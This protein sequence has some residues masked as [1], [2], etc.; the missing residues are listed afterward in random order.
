MAPGP[1]VASKPPRVHGIQITRRLHCL[2][3]CAIKGSAVPCNRSPQTGASPVSSSV[4][5][6]LEHAHNDA[7][8]GCMGVAVAAGCHRAHARLRDAPGPVGF[9][10]YYTL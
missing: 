6:C 1:G 5:C 2:A 8:L 7:S 3:P 10:V 4:G 9:R